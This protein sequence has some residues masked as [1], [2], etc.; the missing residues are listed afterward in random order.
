VSRKFLT[1]KSNSEKPKLRMVSLF[2]GAG[3]LDYGFEAAGF[4]TTVAIEMDS[5]CAATLRRNRPWPVIDKDIHRV[6]AS[7]IRDCG[8]LARGSID[9][10]IGG[11]PCQPFS[12]SGYWANGDT[13]R[14]D[15]PR[16]NTLY[17]YMKCVQELQPT[18]FVLENVHGISY[19]GK[20]EGF[21]LLRRL[22]SQINRKLGSS[23]ALSWNVLNAAEYGI[24]QIRTRFFLVGHRDGR[25][26][27]FPR[28]THCDPATDVCAT[29][30][31]ESQLLPFVTAWDAIA[32]LSPR[33]SEDLRPRGRWADLLPSIPEGE[34]YLWHTNRKGGLSLF[35]WR[36]RY[37]SFLL[38]LAKNRP[39]WTIQAQPGPAI[40]PFHWENRLLSER[41]LAAL[42]TFPKGIRICGSR[43]AVQRQLGNAVPSMLAEIL[44]RAIGEQFFSRK[45]AEYKLA[46]SLKRPI[47]QPEP[48][49]LVPEKYQIFVGQHPDHPG[50][51]KHKNDS[52]SK[53]APKK[54]ARQAAL[55][56][57]TSRVSE[58][59]L[60]R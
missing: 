28:V 49:A 50:T 57:S 38:K 54:T 46:V 7:E 41:E 30:S 53:S 25:M 40:G 35:G 47:P 39:S 59:L 31:K 4:E 17:A 42:Q 14:L 23:Y 45:L 11:P 24:P 55:P 56:F 43:G 22:T 13:L 21:Q 37:W 32:R 19:S 8:E 52:I 48:V 9:V 16:A 26:F 27:Q 44:A 29:L 5:D 51:S 58:T 1:R 18:V 36:T 3:G 6:S 10:L 20:E 34:N 33:P 15:D 12:K 2:T 60:V